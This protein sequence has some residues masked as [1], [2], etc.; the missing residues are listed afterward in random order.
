MSA[1][2]LTE[3]TWLNAHLKA[4]KCIIAAVILEFQQV[5]AVHVQIANDLKHRLAVQDGKQ[6]NPQAYKDANKKARHVIATM[7]DNLI[8]AV[9]LG[10]LF[11]EPSACKHFYLGDQANKEKQRA[12]KLSP[13]N[14]ATRAAPEDFAANRNTASLETMLVPTPKEQMV[15]PPA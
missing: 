8:P 15:P 6:I 10:H 2:M 11:T 1:S 4:H 7:D 5:V 3:K 9:T 12:K 14:N 13:T